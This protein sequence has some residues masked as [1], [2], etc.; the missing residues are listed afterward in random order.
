MDDFVKIAV[1]AIVGG[2]IT[3]IGFV[4][5]ERVA[6]RKESA[7]RR[8]SADI[9]TLESMRKAL[10]EAT[11]KGLR[12]IEPYSGFPKSLIRAFDSF[13][14]EFDVRQVVFHDKEL[15]TL[16][17]EGI[18]AIRNFNNESMKHCVAVG[19]RYATCPERA[20]YRDKSRYVVE[21]KAV[22]D[23]AQK[24]HDSFLSLYDQARSRLEI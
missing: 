22:Y 9:A 17:L 4:Y 15:N 20:D 6:R 8:R 3:A 10:S 18:S 24:V 11:V 2:M 12:E 1:A 7:A 13:L 14:Q 5:K 21:A 16:A 23:L 19:E